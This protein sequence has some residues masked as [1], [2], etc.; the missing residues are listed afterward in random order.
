M[1]KAKDLRYMKTERSIRKAFHKLLQEKDISRI[2]IRELVECAQINKS[3]FYSHYET[4]P[5]LIDTLEKEN[6]DYIMDH[7]DQV[8]LLYKDPDQFIDNL[9]HEL[10]DCRI[11]SI[12]KHG[13]GNQRFIERL[14]KAFADEIDILTVPP[15]HYQRT[16]TLLT[17]ILYGI[18]GVM[19]T[20]SAN[21]DG[22]KY[23]KDLVRNGLI[24]P[25]TSIS[26]K[27]ASI[28]GLDT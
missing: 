18:L 10:L 2:T 13:A 22:I 19:G 28:W 26:N 4:L 8:D 16:L 6:I 3:T 17:F 11:V 14:K 9:Y 25:S 7:L 5:D 27:K 24:I 12:G 1:E 15:E 23:I 20:E 21:D